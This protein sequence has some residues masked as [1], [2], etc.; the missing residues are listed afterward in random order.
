MNKVAVLVAALLLVLAPI[1]EARSLASNSE[2]SEALGSSAIGTD[3]SEP[4]VIT[5]SASSAAS[6]IEASNETITFT[7]TIRVNNGA[8]RRSLLQ[9]NPYIDQI[10]GFLVAITNALGI[11]RPGLIT[12]TCLIGKTTRAQPPPAV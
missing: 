1:A 2:S 7:A 11:E 10:D 5:N 6:E 3:A 9:L 8:R 4:D 12:A